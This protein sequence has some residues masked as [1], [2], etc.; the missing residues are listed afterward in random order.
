MTIR[1]RNV[2]A[3]VRIALRKFQGERKLTGGRR[4][5]S[6]NTSRKTFGECDGSVRVSA[7]SQQEVDFDQNGPG[8]DDLSPQSRQQF[9]SKKMPA[10]LRTVDCRDDRAGVANDQRPKRARISSTFWE[11]SSSS[12]MRPA[13]GSRSGCCCTSSVT[14]ADTDVRRRFASLSRRSAIADGSETVFRTEDIL[15]SMN[16]AV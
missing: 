10:A 4:F 2:N 7:G 3:A 16:F 6:M 1:I 5:Q 8:N 15:Q 12:S 14:R 13:Y 11:R 9:G